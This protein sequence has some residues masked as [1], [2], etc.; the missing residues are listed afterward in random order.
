MTVT[1]LREMVCRPI[2]L[3]TRYFKRLY[4]ICQWKFL[5]YLLIS[6]FIIKGLM[7]K[8]V[9]GSMLPVFKNLGMDA[10]ELQIYMTIAMSP[11]TLKPLIGL[12]SDLI[13]IWHYHKRFWLVQ[14]ILTGIVGS[15]LMFPVGTLPKLLI[16]CYMLVNYEMAVVD[17][18]VEGKYAEKMQENPE[19]GSDIIT[20]VNGLQALGG[21]A[22]MALIGVLSDLQ[23]YSVMFL[24]IALSSVTPLVPSILGWIPEPRVESRRCIAFEVETFT[25]NRGMFIV[26]GF[27]GFAGPVVALLAVYTHPLIGLICAVLLMTAVIGGAF[28][29]FSRLIAK[30]GLY[31]VLIRLVNPSMGTA[32]DYFFTATPECYAD[33]PHFSFKFYIFYT[34]LASQIVGFLTAWAYQGIFSKWRFRNVLIFTSFLVA[35]AGASDFIIVKRLNHYIGISDHIFYFIGEAVL[36]TAVGMLF[37]IPTSTLISKVCPQGL[38]SATYAFLAGLSN[39][40]LMFSELAGA[41]IFQTAGISKC[42]FAGLEWLILGCHIL[43]PLVGGIAAAFLIPNLPQD[44]TLMADEIEMEEQQVSGFVPVEADLDLDLDFD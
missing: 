13:S 18:L 2:E 27:T 41:L 24:L 6:Q 8:M 12:V 32:L 1:R 21:V 37:W 34:G 19:T 16:L 36:E 10:S 38:E 5:A 14:G 29:T 11:W 17:L 42:E 43:L 33:A 28:L 23:L 40:G 30:V 35:F 9:M 20:F 39:F 44:C 4:E 7:Y 22:A 15:L 3:A 25:Q 31:L 26:I